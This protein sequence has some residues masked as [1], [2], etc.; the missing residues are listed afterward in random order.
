MRFYIR[1]HVHV[2]ICTVSQSISYLA[3]NTATFG[4]SLRGFYVYMTTATSVENIL[5]Y[6]SWCFDYII[7]VTQT[8]SMTFYIDY[9]TTTVSGGRSVAW[10]CAQLDRTTSRLSTRMYNRGER[11]NVNNLY[12]RTT[13]YR[14]AN[15][16][17]YLKILIIITITITD[18][19]NSIN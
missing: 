8:S 9:Y 6:N 17:F 14:L 15:P 11:Y 19:T 7:L 10:R 2:H 13:K 5:I 3:S 12:T 16:I 4:K 1:V 18:I